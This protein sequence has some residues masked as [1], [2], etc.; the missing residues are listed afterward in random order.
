[1]LAAVAAHDWM[2]SGGPSDACSELALQ[3]LAGGELVAA[4][5]G[6]L[7]V[8]AIVVLAVADRDEAMEVWE[9]SLA[10]AYR[11][12]SL[13]S[14]KSVTLWRGFTQYWRGELAD[15][16]E[17]LRS[18]GE[19]KRYGLG[20]EAWLYNH[21]LLSAV[22]RERGDL[23]GARRVLEGS[24]DL[25]NRSDATRY[26]LNSKLELLVAEGRFNDAL[27]VAE[28]FA[29]RF[30]H[31][32]SPIDTPWRAPAV[33]ALRRVGREPE[34]RALAA[35]ELEQA[36]RW[37]SPATMARALRTMATLEKD[38]VELLREAADLLAGSP[39]PTGARQGARPHS[40]PR[41]GS[42]ADPL[43]RVRRYAARWS[44]PRCLERRTWLDT[45]APSSTPPA[46]VPA[47]RPWSA[48][49]L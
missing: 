21:A 27:V 41:F 40:A 46:D 19:G 9:Y 10:D 49:R 31:I 24:S 12:G 14:K 38:G 39:G 32:A 42:R 3:A 34:A 36:R 15:A 6:L 20:P 7:G 22:L 37:G 35:Q 25:G 8:T 44:S 33:L 13:L 45:S 16:E 23:P 17:S 29:G 5:N 1:M 26:W 47:P 43:M 30:G 28:D 4:D 18:S 11:R 2:L 48:S